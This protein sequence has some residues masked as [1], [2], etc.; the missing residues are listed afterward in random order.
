MA[1]KPASR[2]AI[3][4]QPDTEVAAEST[5]MTAAVAATMASEARN[6]A[7]P[8]TEIV[9]LTA[10]FG[11]LYIENRAEAS[12]AGHAVL[13]TLAEH[14][15]DADAAI[16][17]AFG[18]PGLGAAK[19]LF[20]FPVVGLAESAMVT[21]W[22]LGGRFS[23]VCLTP[24]LARWYRECAAE[25]GLDKRLASIRALAVPVSDVTTARDELASALAQSC[26]E[27]VEADG[28]EVVILGGGPIA[29]LA[30]SLAEQVPVPLLDGVTCAV[31]VAEMLVALGHRP[32]RLGSY[33]RPAPKPSRGLSPALAR[34]ISGSAQA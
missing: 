12:I 21:A 17:S 20:D 8:G 24:R 7:S 27:A 23:I 32:P 28:A 2:H 22:L 6:A 14:A 4:G 33:A 29:G 16:V 34:R 25:H 1:S 19:E 3:A 11:T 30:R 5:T 15:D 13:E 26:M 9:A 10:P 18:D 31:R